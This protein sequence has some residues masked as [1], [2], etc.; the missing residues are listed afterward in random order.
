MLGDRTMSLLG[1]GVLL[2]LS[3]A[4]ETGEVDAGTGMTGR[5]PLA[6]G[7]LITILNPMTI[8]FWLGI[9]SASLAARPREAMGIE[10]L[11][12]ASLVAG[13]AIW[14]LALALHVGRR[15]IK[16]RV[17][18]AVSVVAGLVLIGFGSDFAWK[19][20]GRG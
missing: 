3:V 13:C 14:T 16:G 2:G 7:F 9:L 17:L 6:G 8:A 4:A 11:Y 1:S 18:R 20:L 12:V 5:G 10:M 15:A 19:A